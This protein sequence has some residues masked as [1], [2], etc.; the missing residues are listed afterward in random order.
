M[1]HNVT[2]CLF[3]ALVAA[4]PAFAVELKTAERVCKSWDLSCPKGTVVYGGKEMKLDRMGCRKPRKDPGL[5]DKQGPQVDCTQDGRVRAF[6]EW[7]NG[8]KDGAWVVYNADGSWFSADYKNGVLEGKEVFHSAEGRVQQETP[9]KAG[10]RHGVSKSFAPDGS[11]SVEE[12]WEKG[13]KVKSVAVGKDGAKHV[14]DFEY[15]RGALKGS[16]LTFGDGTVRTYDAA[17]RAVVSP[18]GGTP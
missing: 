15:A 18:D 17:G 6:G 14:R 9:Y 11:L 12:T 5:I 2:A 10:K 16:R 7:K 4:G 1:M 13:L 3:A 8:K